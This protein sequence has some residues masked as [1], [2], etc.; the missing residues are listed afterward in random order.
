VPAIDLIDFAY[1]SAP[2][3]NDYWHTPADTL[4]KLSAESLDLFGRVVARM[5][6]ELSALRGK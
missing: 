3:L 4:D 6:A 2:G 5:V 1:G